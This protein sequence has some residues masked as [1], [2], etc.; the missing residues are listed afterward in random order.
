MLDV[1]LPATTDAWRFRGIGRIVQL[2]TA[3][4]LTVCIVKR[5][6][7]AVDAKRFPPTAA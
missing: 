6:W 4:L 5:D 3:T 2:S 7:S 1:H